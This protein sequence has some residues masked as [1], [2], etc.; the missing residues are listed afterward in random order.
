[1]DFSKFKKAIAG[2]VAALAAAVTAAYVGDGSVSV[3]E[4]LYILVTTIGAFVAVY[5]TPKNSV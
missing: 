5:R 4:W 1:M 3:E 2:A